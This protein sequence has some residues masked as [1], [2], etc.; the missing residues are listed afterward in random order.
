MIRKPDMESFLP[1]D[2]DPRSVLITVI[3]G[4]GD[5]P[6]LLSQ[7]IK[8][9]GIACRL[10][11]LNGEAS[12]ALRELFSPDEIANANIGQLG[13]V[14]RL[15]KDFGT[16][17]VLLAGQIKPLRLFKDFKPDWRAF[18]LLRKIKERNAET[19]F[20]E[21]CAQIESRGITVLDARS[22]MEDDI[23]AR[24]G[25]FPIDRHVVE[26]GIYIAT[27][28]AR[29]NIGQSV[30][31]KNGTVLC[32]EGFDGTDGM[33]R[34]AGEFHVDDMVFVKTSK[35]HHDFRFDVPIFGETTLKLLH[36][37]GIRYAALEAGKT[38]ILNQKSV[39]Q[40]AKELG[41]TIFGY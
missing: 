30:I 11:S 19:L 29:L 7:R 34:K 28:I 22:F 41:I 10:I 15:L 14:L 8:E 6:Y 40:R 37:S 31:V 21:V 4:R 1:E 35:P 26:H 23:V 39:L 25:K 3:A 16:T 38:I 17:H 2:F 36:E 9:R 20:S 32:V 5:Y 13:K 24:A 12:E 33:I 27:E 18:C